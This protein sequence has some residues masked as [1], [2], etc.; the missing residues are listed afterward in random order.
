MT[1]WDK[2][3]TVGGSQ[4]LLG[5]GTVGRS[6]GCTLY[7]MG[8]TECVLSGHIL[9]GIQSGDWNTDSVFFGK[10]PNP[11]RPRFPHF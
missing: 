9:K 6:S 8:E 2:S 5:L 4:A 10:S 3:A 1:N 11:S 7:A